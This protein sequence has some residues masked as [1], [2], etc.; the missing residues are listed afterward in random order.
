MAV[1][2]PSLQ[3][4]TSGASSLGRGEPGPDGVRGETGPAAG[5]G[6]PNLPLNEQGFISKSPWS[7]RSG[8]GV[9]V[10]MCVGGVSVNM[11]VCVCVG[12][13]YVC[14]GGYVCGYV[15]V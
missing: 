12:C 4:C 13:V 9:C 10:C 2:P 8:A 5:A 14:V 3:V 6:V 7:L 15:C 1:S 11:C